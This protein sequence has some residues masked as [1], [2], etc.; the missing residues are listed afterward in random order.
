MN[1]NQREKL[2]DRWS[3]QSDCLP[4]LVNQKSCCNS[5]KK[6]CS[7]D[8]K[9]QQSYMLFLCASD[10]YVP[11]F[12]SQSVFTPTSFC[13]ITD[14]WMNKMGCYTVQCG[15]YTLAIRKNEIRMHAATWRNPEDFYAVKEGSPKAC[16]IPFP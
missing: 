15:I 8:E 4:C 5:H 6:P 14:G 10:R 16:V 3:T 2:A 1:K 12:L 13:T 11:H 7:A 9:Q